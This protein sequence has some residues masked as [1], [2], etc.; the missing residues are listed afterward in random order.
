MYTQFVRLRGCPFPL[1]MQMCDGEDGTGACECDKE[2]SRFFQFPSNSPPVHKTE[3]HKQFTALLK[4]F[5][6]CGSIQLV[7]AR[8]N[9]HRQHGRYPPTVIMHAAGVW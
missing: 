4:E 6:L 1:F 2:R 9:N 8:A 3:Y 5:N 7:L